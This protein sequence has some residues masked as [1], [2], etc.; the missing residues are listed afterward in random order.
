MVILLVFVMII[1]TVLDLNSKKKVAGRIEE[2]DEL[3]QFKIMQN[4]LN[5]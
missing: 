2:N 5:N 4:C 3:Y 1:I